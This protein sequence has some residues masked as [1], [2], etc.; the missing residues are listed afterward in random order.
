[1]AGTNKKIIKVGDSAREN[2]RARSAWAAPGSRNGGR[3]GPGHSML[4]PRRRVV[5]PP[6]RRDLMKHRRCLFNFK[7]EENVGRDRGEASA[8]SV[9]PVWLTFALT[10]G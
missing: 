7:S 2:G 10:T 9:P 8:Q 4:P 3:I 5:S 6:T 1:M